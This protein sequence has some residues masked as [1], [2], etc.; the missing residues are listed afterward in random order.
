MG[1]K[2]ASKTRRLRGPDKSRQIPDGKPVKQSIRIQNP[3]LSTHFER[4]TTHRVHLRVHLAP[5]TM[6][7]TIAGDALGGSRTIWEALRYPRQ[8]PRRQRSIARE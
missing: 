1:R 2:N 6:H 7:G 4:V 8:S 3:T 5:K